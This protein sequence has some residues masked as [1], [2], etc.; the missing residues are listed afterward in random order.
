MFFYK[1]AC[2]SALVLSLAAA[3][4]EAKEVFSRAELAMG[5]LISVQIKADKQEESDICYDAAAAEINRLEKIFSSYIED[6]DV[7]RI[8]ATPGQWV[9][10]TPETAELLALSVE[11]AGLTEGAFDPT[12][13]SLVKLW[14]ADQVYH[15]IP[16][17]EEI[18]EA[19]KYVGYDKIEVKEEN[20]QHFAKIGEHQRIT[21]GG[22]AKGYI[23]DR[24]I[25]V[26]NKK[27]CPDAL[28]SFGGDVT[29]TGTNAEDV[30]WRLGIQ[31]P[32]AKNGAYFAVISLDNASIQTS[33]DYERFFIQDGVKYHHIISPTTGRP[34]KATLSSV[35][36]LHETSAPADALCTALFVMGWDG[37]I[38]YL[39]KRPGLKAVL[40]DGDKKRVAVSESLKD[41]LKVA[42]EGLELFVIK[43]PKTIP[44]EPAGSK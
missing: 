7:S 8:N 10:I 26:V 24:V 2:I 3:P 12:V 28:L 31:Y 14:S 41:N 27:G 40:M 1:V 20:G 23:L 44:Q 22:I 33:G 5:T 35:T 17:D 43:A 18:Q 15:R 9:A 36:I 6:S 13:G 16:A 25:E 32:G 42:L 11:M 34:V 30:P 19:L 4:A 38:D 39:S 21:L 37:A 29:G